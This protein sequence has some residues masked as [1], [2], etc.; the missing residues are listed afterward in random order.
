[1]Q[2]AGVKQYNHNHKFLQARQLQEKI[3]YFGWRNHNKNLT[4]RDENQHFLILYITTCS[5]GYKYGA[6]I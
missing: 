1:M 2:A 6:K 4:H 3:K 5:Q